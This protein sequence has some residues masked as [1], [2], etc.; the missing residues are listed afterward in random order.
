M[1]CWPPGGPAPGRRFNRRRHD[2][3]QTIAAF[4]ARL[5]NQIDLDTLS[6]GVV[7]VAGQTMEPTI[8]SL[9]LRPPMERSEEGGSTS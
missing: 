6:A 2:T 3:R 5:R 4:S 1:R 7:T 8:L 9:W